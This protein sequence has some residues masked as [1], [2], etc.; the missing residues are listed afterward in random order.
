MRYLA[1]YHKGKFVQAAIGGGF[2]LDR[3][4]QVPSLCYHN[5]LSWGC[6]GHRPMF[7]AVRHGDIDGLPTKVEVRLLRVAKRPLAHPLGDHLQCC[8]LQ[9]SL[10]YWRRAAR[11]TE[12]V[13]LPMMALRL[14]SS[15][16]NTAISLADFPCIHK[17]LRRSTFSSVHTIMRNTLPR[18]DYHPHRCAARSVESARANLR[19]DGVPGFR[20]IRHRAHS[21]RHPPERAC[22]SLPI[23]GI[24][25]PDPI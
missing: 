1:V 5:W 8:E 4:F 12:A 24:P 7:S 3:P 22:Y 25:S 14:I 2:A 18:S 10:F 21:H 17:D 19:S 23:I 9:L 20:M 16:I 6:V 11:E 15:P 13:A